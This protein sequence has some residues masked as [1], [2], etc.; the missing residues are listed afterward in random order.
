M[1]VIP[2][3]LENDLMSLSHPKKHDQEAWAQRFDA[4][5]RRGHA[6]TLGDRER[7]RVARYTCTRAVGVSRAHGGIRPTQD[8]R[9]RN[10]ILRL[11]GTIWRPHQAC[12]TAAQPCPAGTRI[13][14][15]TLSV[16][17][18]AQ[19]RT[20]SVTYCVVSACSRPCRAADAGPAWIWI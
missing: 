1:H 13:G 20:H 6:R 14:D 12:L 3:R 2:S 17:D 9:E 19:L 5:T 7:Y 10:N 18:S 8:A 15:Q 11:L 4:R 16:T